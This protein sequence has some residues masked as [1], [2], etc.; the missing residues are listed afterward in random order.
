MTVNVVTFE[1]FREYLGRTVISRQQLLLR[2]RPVDPIVVRRHE[3]S[4]L[5]LSFQRSSNAT[6]AVRRP[7][8]NVRIP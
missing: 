2:H 4:L 3:P 6:T 7:W 5:P 1:S 8:N